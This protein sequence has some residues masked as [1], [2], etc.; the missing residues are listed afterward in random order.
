M[1]RRRS[2]S[3]SCGAC[4]TC[5]WVWTVGIRDTAKQDNMIGLCLF[6]SVMANSKSAYTT[7]GAGISNCWFVNRRW[8]CC[9]SNSYWSR[10]STW[11]RCICASWFWM[12]F[13]NRRNH[14]TYTSCFWRDFYSSHH[15]GY[16]CVV[17]IRSSPWWIWSVWGWCLSLETIGCVWFKI[18]RD[19]RLVDMWCEYVWELVNRSFLSLELSSYP[20]NRVTSNTLSNTFNSSSNLENFSSIWS[21]G[22][23]SHMPIASSIS[24]IVTLNTLY[25]FGCFHHLFPHLHHPFSICDDLCP[26]SLARMRHRCRHRL[27]SIISKDWQLIVQGWKV[28]V[29]CNPRISEVETSR[30][31]N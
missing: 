3:S 2:L 12:L 29:V 1:K 11:S 20:G 13:V 30:Y 24:W 5:S 16:K 27:S 23:L 15:S 31:G 26:P 9:D 8:I 18:Q 25:L 28:W 10:S 14:R 7:T 4:N 22:L 6:F 21:K 19:K 17:W